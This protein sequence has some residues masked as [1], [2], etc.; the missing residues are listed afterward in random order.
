MRLQ[1]RCSVYTIGM[2]TSIVDK[3]AP[4]MCLPCGRSSFR[5]SAWMTPGRLPSRGSYLCSVSR[6]SCSKRLPLGR[7]ENITVGIG[8]MDTL[9]QAAHHLCTVT[10]SKNECRLKIGHERLH[11]KTIQL[12]PYMGQAPKSEISPLHSPRLY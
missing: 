10:V 3:H 8:R 5:T 6:T 4:A 12:S 2:S 1:R 11:K 7:I 9:D